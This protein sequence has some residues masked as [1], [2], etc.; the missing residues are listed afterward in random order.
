MK[1]PVEKGVSI[2]GEKLREM[3]KKEGWSQQQLSRDMGYG[4]QY[5]SVA[6]ASGRISKRAVRLLRAIGI[7]PDEYVIPETAENVVQE[8]PVNADPT[9]SGLQEKLTETAEQPMGYGITE[10]LALKR[11]AVIQSELCLALMYRLDADIRSQMVTSPSQKQDDIV[12]IRR[13][14]NNLKYILQWEQ[15]GGEYEIN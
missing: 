15:M 14:L 13:E 11:K 12:K 6:I 2:N 1:K 3:L 9:I 4:K 10:K 7:D 5:L 8:K